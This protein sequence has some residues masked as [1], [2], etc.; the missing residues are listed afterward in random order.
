MILHK[1]CKVSNFK[2]KLIQIFNLLHKIWNKIKIQDLSNGVLPKTP[3]WDELQ[4]KEYRS[5]GEFYRKASQILKREDSKEAVRKAEGATT[6][7]KN[8]QGETAD[9]KSKD[10]WRGEDK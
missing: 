7:K 6:N 4:Q 5:V 1:S 8:D 9:D 2:L 10:N 3:L